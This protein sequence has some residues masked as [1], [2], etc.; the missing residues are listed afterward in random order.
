M[1]KSAKKSAVLVI[2]AYE[3]KKFAHQFSKKGEMETKKHEDSGGGVERA[4]RWL[5]K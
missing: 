1:N 4:D 2:P 5:C 3:E